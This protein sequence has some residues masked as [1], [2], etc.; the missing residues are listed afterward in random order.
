MLIRPDHTKYLTSANFNVFFGVNDH[1]I[2]VG[3]QFAD[4]VFRG[5]IEDYYLNESLDVFSWGNPE[6]RIWKV[7]TTKG[8]EVVEDTPCN[9]PVV[10]LRGRHNASHWRLHTDYSRGYRDACIAGSEEG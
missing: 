9:L 6:R 2:I 7:A 5:I 10:T 1:T 4:P 8:V 3:R